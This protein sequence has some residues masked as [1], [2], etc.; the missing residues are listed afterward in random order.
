MKSNRGKRG[1]FIIIA[2]MLTA[3]M[4]VSIGALMHRAITY[5]RHEPWEEYS[6][7]IGD[8]EVNSHKVVELSLASYTNSI[9]DTNILSDNLAEWQKDLSTVYISKGIRLSSSG[10][11]LSQGS[12]PIAKAGFTLNIDSIGLEGYTFSVT[13][14]LH[15][16]IVAIE[17]SVAPFN[18]NATLASETGESVSGLELNNFRLDGNVPSA[19]TPLLDGNNIRVYK[20]QFQGALPAEVAVVDQRGIRAVSSTQ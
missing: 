19:V 20:I 18:I 7:L 1:Q 2:V 16:K 17:S 4:M 13:T 3:I 10:Y 5:Y 8:I 14:S 11:E 9:G 15:L 6:T 12:N